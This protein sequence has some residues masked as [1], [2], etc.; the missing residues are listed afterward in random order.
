MN[1]LQKMVITIAWAETKQTSNGNMMTKL[2]DQNGKSYTLFHTKSDGSESKAYQVLKLLPNNGIGLT[3]EISYSEDSFKGE[4]GKDIVSKKI[5][6]ISSTTE[7]P[8]ASATPTFKQF[9]GAKKA[10]QDVDW[11]KIAEGKCRHG[12]A[13]EAFKMCM[14]LN[15]ET[16]NT[17]NEWTEF[18]MIGSPKIKI[19][20][21]NED[22]DISEVS[23]DEAAF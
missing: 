12:F 5:V 1:D 9:K 14:P 17:I 11:D 15:Q 13:L 22:F 6:G 4:W 19:E 3:K 10:E 20:E 21:N 8:T 7:T 2:K 16:M 23:E 18:S